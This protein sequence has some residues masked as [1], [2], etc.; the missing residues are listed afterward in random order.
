MKYAK[1]E[2]IKWEEWEAKKKNE[3]NFSYRCCYCK[4]YTLYSIIYAIYICTKVW[5]YYEHFPF[6]SIL[7]FCRFVFHSLRKS[8]LTCTFLLR[9]MDRRR[10]IWNSKIPNGKIYRQFHMILHLA[11]LHL[12]LNVLLNECFIHICHYQ[13]LCIIFLFLPLFD[14]KLQKFLFEM[15]LVQHRWMDGK[16]IYYFIL[17]FILDFIM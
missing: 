2:I 7:R 13:S 11:K 6:Q 5:C 8:C 1:N 9:W 17:D 16:K 3:L 15:K 14:V 12:T 4:C 10:N